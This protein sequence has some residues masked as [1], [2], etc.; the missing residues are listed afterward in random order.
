MN[1]DIAEL[2]TEQL[3]EEQRLH[4]S[5]DF[6]NTEVSESLENSLKNMHLYLKGGMPSYTQETIRMFSN[7]TDDEF[8]MERNGVKKKV[9][10]AKR[11]LRNFGRDGRNDA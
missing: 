9:R 3:E 11:S 10:E 4:R 8:W 7:K 2:L 1:V 5:G 6:A